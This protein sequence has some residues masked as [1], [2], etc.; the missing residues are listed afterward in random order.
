MSIKLF[1]NT[2]FISFITFIIP[3][4]LEAHPLDLVFSGH[5]QAIHSVAYSPDGKILATYSDDTTIRLWNPNSGQLFRVIDTFHGAGLDFSPDGSILA[6]GGGNEKGINLWNPET[7]ELL[8]VLNGNHTFI[9]NIAFSPIGDIFASGSRDGQID[10]WNPKTGKLIRSWK[11][12]NIDG[13]SYSADGSLLASGEYKDNSVNVW[14]VN[15]GALIHNFN[16]SGHGIFD[17]AFSSEDFTLAAVGWGA[18]DIWDANTGINKRS[19]KK[20]S[21]RILFCVDISQDGRILATGKDDGKISLWD[22][23]TGSLIQNLKVDNIEIYDIVISPDGNTLTSVGND[24][25]IRHWNITPADDLVIPEIPNVFMDDNVNTWVEDFDEPNLNSWT[26]LEHQRDRASWEITDGKLEVNT[27]PFCRDRLN[28]GDELAQE[29]NTTLEFTAF[30]I[31]LE[32][33]RVKLKVNSTDNAFAGIF[34]GKKPDSLFVRQ[35]KNTYLFGNHTI[36]NPDN[37]TFNAAPSIGYNINEID[38]IFDRGHFYLFSEGKYISDFKESSIDKINYVGIATFV[39]RC[40][41]NAFAILDDFEISGPNIPNN[42]PVKVEPQENLNDEK[43]DIK[44]AWIENF[45]DTELKSWKQPKH[46]IDNNRSTWKP[47]DGVLDVWIEPL[48]HHA[49]FQTYILEFVGFEIKTKTVN[50][51]MDVLE[52]VNSNVGFIIGQRT[53]DGNIYRRTYDIL[54]SGIW[55]PPAFKGQDPKVNFGPL[56]NIE[57]DFNNGHFELLS[58]GEHIL[59]F[60]EPNIPYIDVLGIIAY[61]SEVPLSH[62]VVDNFIISNVA[63][64]NNQNLNV[65]AKG[66]AT[67]LWGELKN[68]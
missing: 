16:G 62:F 42:G 63:N 44:D 61:T 41:E 1:V 8:R 64:Q 22:M 32:Q 13:L 11:A 10:I 45:S 19:I 39:D 66:K 53:P 60:D 47:K 52:A 31:D 4:T 54:Q 34:I 51:K 58:E 49:L 65:E 37:L 25:L 38:V 3:L 20:D 24:D 55:G 9:G 14:N 29:T 23:N 59:E 5:T 56:K 30:P 21:G 18:I 68:K 43:I 36:G 27:Q 26:T 17:I 46:Q 67:I 40:S 33:L 50:V 35:F 2:L 15:T 12:G 6:S 48:Q 28:L 7:G 57:I